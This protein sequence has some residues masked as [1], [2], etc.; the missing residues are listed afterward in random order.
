MKG[1]TCFSSPPLTSTQGFSPYTPYIPLVTLE[2]LTMFACK[3]LDFQQK[4]NSSERIKVS[5]EKRGFSA[6]LGLCIPTALQ[7]R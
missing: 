7:E 3:V 6:F 5:M 4:Q 1:I 2:V